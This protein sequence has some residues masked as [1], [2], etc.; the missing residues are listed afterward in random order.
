MFLTASP[1]M[2]RWIVASCEI[3]VGIR[4]VINGSGG[5]GS[6]SMQQQHLFEKSFCFKGQLHNYSTPV[7]SFQRVQEPVDGHVFVPGWEAS[8]LLQSRYLLSQPAGNPDTPLSP[9]LCP[10]RNTV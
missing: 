8:T 2:G 1:L 3:Y 7:H 5:A 6:Q 10:R 4:I 9:E